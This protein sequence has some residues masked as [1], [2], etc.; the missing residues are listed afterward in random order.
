MSTAPKRHTVPYSEFSVLQLAKEIL[1]SEGN[2]LL[3]LPAQLDQRFCDAV[4]LLTKCRS[5]VVLTGIG[6]AGLIAQKVSATLSSTGTSSAVKS[7]S[8]TSTRKKPRSSR[9]ASSR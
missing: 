2:A 9:S 6:K 3:K 1:N 5:N 7:P 4:D 8:S